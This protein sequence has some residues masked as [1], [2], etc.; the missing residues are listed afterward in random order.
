MS[1]DVE[2]LWRSVVGEREPWR[3]GRLFL[4]TTGVLAALSQLYLLALGIFGGLLDQVIAD[5]IGILLFWLAF[6]FIWIGVH[7][8][9]WIQGACTALFGLTLALRGVEGSSGLLIVLGLFD[10][11]LGA[12]L[13]LAP[14]IYFFALRQRESRSWQMAVAVAAIFALLVASLACGAWG[15]TIYRQMLASEARQFAG[16]AFRRLFAEHDTY[17]LLDHAAPRMLAPPF[18]RAYLTRYLQVATIRAGDVHA[19]QPAQGSV[20]LRCGLPLKVYLEGDMQA[21]AICE[22]GHIVLSMHVHGLPGNWLI[23]QLGW[24]LPPSH[25]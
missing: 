20:A 17:F 2:P 5:A 16:T 15:L 22:R 10:L 8:V 24:I 21:D 14:A 19:F 1:D 25:S 13:A 9:R 18:G 3:R 23:D 12:Y 6:Y 7:W 4:I 11:A